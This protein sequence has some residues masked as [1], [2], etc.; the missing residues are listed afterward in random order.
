MVRG[1][2]AVTLAVSDMA[3]SVG[4][5]EK[6][7]LQRV[8]GGRDAS[9]STFRVGDG[10]LN[11]AHSTGGVRSWWGRIILRIE[12]VDS[13]YQGLKDRG[14]E[15]EG[16]PRDAEW[17][18]RYFH[19]NDPD[20]HE[21]SFA[22]LLPGKIPRSHDFPEWTG[23]L[24][25]DS[26]KKRL[27]EARVARLSTSDRRHLPHAIPICFAYDGCCLYTALD[28]KSKRRAPERLTRVR[29]IAT[30]PNVSVLIDEYH[31]DWAKLWYVLVRGNAEVLPNGAERQKALRLLRE[32]YP[33]YTS[34]D[35]LPEN[36]Q[37]IR[38]TPARMIS[39]A[40]EK[41]TE[42]SEESEE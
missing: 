36:A 39:W 11:L 41:N 18:E 10:F 14:V 21:L 20:G 19:I 40:A 5:Y 17:G 9:F 33:P 34:S 3:R 31:E 4:F 12:G 7:G 42:E 35:L 13:F 15:P 2:S 32:K 8:R 6:I 29:N 22:E 28:L 38:I 30:N 16:Q 27:Q 24:D 23:S 1:I 37:V 26:A 25:Q